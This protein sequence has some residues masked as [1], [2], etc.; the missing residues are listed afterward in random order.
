[1]G[2]RMMIKREVMNIKVMVKIRRVK[3]RKI[4]PYFRYVIHYVHPY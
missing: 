2:E 1:M 4:S 3:I